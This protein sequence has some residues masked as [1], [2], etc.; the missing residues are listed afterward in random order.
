[1]GLGEQAVRGRFFF[2]ERVDGSK[3]V[4]PAIEV[5]CILILFL[6]IPFAMCASVVRPCGAPEVSRSRQ[7]V[8]FSWGELCFLFMT[9]SVFAWCAFCENDRDF[10]TF[11][12]CQNRLHLLCRVFFQF[13]S[14]FY[15]TA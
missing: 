6:L 9:Q 11:Q 13:H 3:T 5:V 14:E 7:V 12:C 2:F 4:V 1:M 15:A 8:F 10:F